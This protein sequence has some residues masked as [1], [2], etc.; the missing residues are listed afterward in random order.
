MNDPI[1]LLRTT[2]AVNA[3]SSGLCGAAVFAAAVPLAPLLGLSG[4]RPLLVFGALLA[5]F[6]LY[7]WNARR[8]PL[9]LGKVQAIFV[10]DVAYVVLSF[11]L[12]LGWPGA[13]SPLGRLATA[14]VADL[15]ALFAVL[16]Y[17]GL[18]R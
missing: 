4:P 13:L 11:A 16:E 5:A 10:M 9:D 12:V 18:R 3:V 15:V 7:V 1:R 6:A 14:M 17:V 2:F 8:E